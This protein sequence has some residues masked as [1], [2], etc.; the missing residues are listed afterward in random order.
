MSVEAGAWEASSFHGREDD[1]EMLRGL[2]DHARLV[3]VL[4]PG[5]MG[6]TRLAMRHLRAV[7]GSY[8]DAGG[9]WAIDLASVGTEAGLL[10]AVAHAL[11]VKDEASSSEQA[12]LAAHLER[13][14]PT[15]ILLDNF[16]HL[17]GACAPT[18]ERWLRAAPALRLLMTSRVALGLPGEHVLDLEP[19][20]P[21]D[22]VSLFVA[23]ARAMAPD[24]TVDRAV[25]R[26]IVDAIDGMPL[27]IELAASR[28]RILTLGE[29]LHRLERPLDVLVGKRVGGRH[30]S[31]RRAVH[32]S[33][34]LLEPS[35]R[36]VFALLSVLENGFGTS[37]AEAI[38]GVRV[39]A[40]SA[41][42]DALDVLAR[43]SLLQSDRTAE[44][45]RHHFFQ[46]VREVARETA[47]QDPL[48]PEVEA[49]HAAH[50]ASLAREHVL[51]GSPDLPARSGVTTGDVDNM[52][53]AHRWCLQMPGETARAQE[54]ALALD[55][56]LAARGQL[57]HRRE[58]LAQTL[59]LHAE[60]DHPL[61]VRLLLAHGRAV[62]DAGETKA[63]LEILEDALTRVDRTEDPLLAAELLVALGGIDDVIG[64]T[65]RARA[66]YGAALAL[67]ADRSSR[68]ALHVVVDARLALA[69]AHRREGELDAG[70][71]MASAAASAAGTL[72][73]P[74]GRA[75][76][77]YELAT[78]AMFGKRE[79]GADAHLVKGLGI[80]RESALPI[81]EGA[82]NTARGCLLQLQGNSLEARSC[83]AEAA[84]IFGD[85][86]SRHREGSALYY[87]ATTYLEV[88]EA[89]EALPIL[90]RARKRLAPIGAPRYEALV[91]AA[92][93]LIHAEL[94]H[95]EEAEAMM[96]RA[97]ASSEQ[98]LHEPALQI[99]IA[100][101]RWALD[102]RT[103]EEGALERKL[104]EASEQV[105][106]HGT[107]DTHF[108]FRMLERMTNG[109]VVAAGE[110]AGALIVWRDRCAFQVPEDPSPVVLRAGS[111]NQRIFARLVERRLAEPGERVSLEEII[112]AGW[113]SERIAAEAALNRAYVAIA[114][115][116][117]KGLR[118]VLDKVAGGYALSPGLPVRQRDEPGQ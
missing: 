100:L 79:S 55:V 29:L 58:L 95:H 83:H 115:L 4:G 36:R 18:L 5:G 109:S 54:L 52:L 93:A 8:E 106:Q 61:R 107:D 111:P 113:P 3:T 39:V 66:R 49:A 17:A 71:D 26:S 31:V 27:A 76:A 108:A 97:E 37:D 117:K 104:R 59:E 92:L 44:P 7:R 16:E 64:E 68:A 101:Q 91:A 47:S 9:A 14:G 38:L 1:L 19:L 103:K 94:G 35:E 45:A 53:V 116:R 32:D 10:A 78:L 96:T 13:R 6:K 90:E 69:H 50:F 62:R 84:R 102:G 34:D 11:D 2:L 42:L 74:L 73:D 60:E 77:H 82:M 30:D 85:C 105:E 21:A 81:M 114:T 20:P 89:A 15:L 118:G 51:G 63:A 41:V 87:L 98:V 40:R 70:V 25:I 33:L 88:G 24:T 67:V 99:S 56:P 80:A 110:Q 46:T 65:G 112:S 23:R 28:T 57:Q 43:T 75:T 48:L 22:A 86:G 72:A 12:R